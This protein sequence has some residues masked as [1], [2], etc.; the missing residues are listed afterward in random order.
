MASMKVTKEVTVIVGN[1]ERD[2]GNSNVPDLKTFQISDRHTDV[3]A[4]DLSA[5]WGISL[6]QATI[7]LNNTTKKLL[8]SAVL[9][10][11]R[12]YHTDR[13]LTRRTP[14][15]QWSCDT[16]NG[17]CKSVDGNQYAQVFG[18]KSYFAKVYP[19]NYKQSSKGNIA[20]VPLDPVAD[21]IHMLN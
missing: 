6:Y 19:M 14:Q 5:L 4:Y 10:L 2:I 20:Y 8:R 9:P 1:E 3:T 12:I 16:M 11:A 13:V 7:T 15:G 21:Y 17:R 18:N